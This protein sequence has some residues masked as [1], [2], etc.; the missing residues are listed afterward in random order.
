MGLFSLLDD[1]RERVFRIWAP[2]VQNLVAFWIIKHLSILN[3]CFEK[4]RWMMQGNVWE[5]GIKSKWHFWVWIQR[6]LWVSGSKFVSF[7]IFQNCFFNESFQNNSL[8][9]L[10]WFFC[11]NFSWG[12]PRSHW[13]SVG[14]IMCYYGIVH[15]NKHL[16]SIFFPHQNL[17]VFFFFFLSVCGCILTWC[18]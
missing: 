3:P 17:L 1:E 10:V 15:L 16:I 18:N 11:F 14:L 13:I 9:I 5:L 8:L 12:S 4:L 7:E 2:H 6:H